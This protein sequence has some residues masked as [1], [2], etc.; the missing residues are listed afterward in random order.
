M[1]YITTIF[2]CVCLKPALAQTL[3]F[4]VEGVSIVMTGS[5]TTITIGYRVD[6]ASFTGRYSFVLDAPETTIPI[7]NGY[8]ILTNARTSLPGNN[9]VG[10]VQVK[11][12][13]FTGASGLYTLRLRGRLEMEST[14]PTVITDFSST[15]PTITINFSTPAIFPPA[16][17]VSTLIDLYRRAIVNLDSGY[18]C[19][20]N[21]TAPIRGVRNLKRA[22]AVQSDV[23]D[24]NLL[25]VFNNVVFG[26]S[27]NF[28]NGSAGAI[29]QD[30]TAG[31]VS[32]A[33]TFR[34]TFGNKTTRAFNLGF[35]AKSSGAFYDVFSA[36]SW[37]KEAG[38]NFGHIW[39]VNN[40][41]QNFDTAKCGAVRTK[42]DDFYLKILSSFM[43][44]L[45]L[46][47]QA[48]RA[49]KQELDRQLDFRTGTLTT[50][51][52]LNQLTSERT[53]LEKKISEYN[54]IYTGLLNSGVPDIDSAEAIVKR[55]LIRFDKENDVLTG[56][57]VNWYEVRGGIAYVDTRF[58]TASAP[59]AD[60][61]MLAAKGLP[62]VNL[63]FS[64]NWTR[65]PTYEVGSKGLLVFGQLSLGLERGSFLDVPR[66]VGK[67][68]FDTAKQGDPAIVNSDNDNI[69]GRFS[70]L[71]KPVW[72][73][74]PGGYL[75]FFMGK[76][77]LFGWDVRFVYRRIFSQPS[78]S[79]LN[80]FYNFFTGPVF[81]IAGEKDFSKATIGLKVG[82]TNAPTGTDRLWKDF[83]TARIEVGVPFRW[84]YKTKS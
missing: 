70:E 80:D 31:T 75:A 20:Q 43:E 12:K 46:P 9:P 28:I 3:R 63:Q 72:S 8:T 50:T 38:L 76:S 51:R 78:T 81:R 83:F 39:I 77:Q 17:S 54:R 71:N 57:W 25:T 62:K 58:D 16:H 33:N 56:Y 21:D 59:K 48:I 24:S 49:R 1:R 41:A 73:F 47:I 44:V 6:A 22:T 40:A 45:S 52:I 5:D 37:R 69:I 30:K 15:G 34:P 61:K 29:T 60:R 27:D 13:R 64:A 84:Y 7:L 67:P 11:L 26:V 53:D 18:N 74:L 2:F 36:N 68:K 32:F 10:L 42:R 23:L 19:F 82:F 35:N 66:M 55:E 65:N 4:D 14:S 79:S